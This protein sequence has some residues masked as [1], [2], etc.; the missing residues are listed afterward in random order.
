MNESDSP[1]APTTAAAGL[2]EPHLDTARDAEFAAFYRTTTTPLVAFLITQG[3]TLADAADIA[4]DTMTKTYRAWRGIEHPRAWVYRVA[5]RAWIRRLVDRRD[6]PVEQPPQPR[7]LLLRSHAVD[8]WELR[9]DL[10]RALADLPHRQRQIMVWTLAEYTPTEIAA[11][12]QMTPGT[13][14]QNLYLARRSLMT[15]L[16]GKDGD[17]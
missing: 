14:R 6:T 9:Q 10:I 17:Q 16:F 3:A 2:G 15:A 5:S 11:E 1:D 4:Q 12:L 7:S 13:V 8:G